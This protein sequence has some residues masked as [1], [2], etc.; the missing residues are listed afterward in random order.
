MQRRRLSAIKPSRPEELRFVHSQAA[1]VV[2]GVAMLRE[3]SIMNF[4]SWSDTGKF[5]LAPITVF[6]GVNSAG[7]S[8]LI[9][10]LLMLKQTVESPDLR[11]VLH[12]GDSETQVELGTFRDLVYRHD[13]SRTIEFSMEWDLPKRLYA[14][15]LTNDA[16][17]SGE[18]LSFRAS[19]ESDA[20]GGRQSVRSLEYQL[21]SGATDL[22]VSMTKNEGKEDY[23]LEASPYKLVR[24]PGR[25][26]KLGHPIRFYGFPDEVRAY[27]QNAKFTSD[28]ALELERQFRRIQYLG[29]LRTIPS[30]SYIWSGET[31]EHVGWSG[32][33]AIEAL[34]GDRKRKISPA[35]HKRTRPF[36]EVIASWLEKMGLLRSFEVTRVGEHRKE[37]EV[38]VQTQAAGPKVNLPDVGFG[39]S[40]IL[41]VVVQCF[42]AQPY[43]TI[44]L[45]Q[46]EIH[47]HPAV[48]M[49]LADLFIETVQS[50]ENGEDRQIQLVVESHSE[51]LL[52]RL[53]TRIAERAISPEDVAL[54]W[55]K[56]GE[57][58][59]VLEP[60]RTNLLGDIENWPDNFFGNEIGEMAHRL[61]AAAA[62]KPEDVQA[63]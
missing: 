15:D 13:L 53:Q 11:R 26:W 48:Q 17:Y 36:E 45:E 55:C 28:F 50:R 62:Q 59:A 22:S 40:Q 6:F 30:R 14:I 27:Y 19:I 37:Y 51:H 61:E 60:L 29:P 4:K 41:P 21:K 34:L 25:V 39:V 52:R 46:P 47:L 10:F 56:L 3:L 1:I 57:D 9:Q 63:K 32:K 44:L 31:P 23:T 33:R 54:Y 2:R 24:N 16:N 49:T 43:T 5:R 38:L 20:S 42:H 35:P 18:Q 12:P 7:K 8:S 58:G